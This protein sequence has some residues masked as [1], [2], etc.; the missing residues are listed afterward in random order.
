MRLKNKVAVVTGS[1]RGIGLAI[2]KLFIKEGAKVIACDLDETELN[3]SLNY[4][5]YLSK[6]LVLNLC[7]VT[8]QHMCDQVFHIAKK[9]I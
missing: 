2:V 8:D 3:K 7:D 4:L 6:N 9:K 5:K 1:A